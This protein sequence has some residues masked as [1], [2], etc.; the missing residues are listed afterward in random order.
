MLASL[1]PPSFSIGPGAMTKWI[2]DL[3]SQDLQRHRDA[4][5]EEEYWRQHPVARITAT[6]FQEL[7][8]AARGQCEELDR[9][10]GASSERRCVYVRESDKSFKLANARYSRTL[11]ADISSRQWINVR[12]CPYVYD[13][14]GRGYHTLKGADLRERLTPADVA[15]IF[16]QWVVG[17]S[18]LSSL[19][20]FQPPLPPYSPSGAI[21]YG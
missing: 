11:D 20:W 16:I 2:D 15:A 9:R 8:E 7:A 5:K 1:P 19:P 4:A 10:F 13:A 12:L 14:N 17:S 21:Q 18:D 3:E 6:F